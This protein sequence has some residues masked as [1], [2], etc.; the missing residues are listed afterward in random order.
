MPLTFLDLQDEVL[1]DEFDSGKYRTLVKRWL[2]EAAA[3]VANALRLPTTDVKGT[4]IALVAGTQTYTLTSSMN[5][6]DSIVLNGRNLIELDI[7]ELDEFDTAARGTPT[8]W[9][10]Y[11][12]EL[13]FWPTPSAAV[14]PTVRYQNDQSQMSGDTDTLTVPDEYADVLVNYAKAKAFAAEDDPEMAQFFRTWFE[15]ELTRMRQQVQERSR[16]RTRQ[17]QGMMPSR[18]TALPRFERP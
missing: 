9:A 2:N 1:H 12:N 14:S 3:K 13:T 15:T 5:R 4:P 7:N 18:T 10:I 8:H 11:G 16:N 6:I 17:V